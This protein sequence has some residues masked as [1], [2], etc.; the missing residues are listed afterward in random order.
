MTGAVYAK[1]HHREVL[2]PYLNMVNLMI[3]VEAEFDLMI[4]VEDI[5]PANFRSIAAISRLI[6]KLLHDV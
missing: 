5:T 2:L 6:A 4:P 3:S 1:Y